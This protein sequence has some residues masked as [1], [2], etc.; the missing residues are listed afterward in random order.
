MLLAI[1]LGVS[2][3]KAVWRSTSGVEEDDFDL[4]SVEYDRVVGNAD[5]FV[6]EDP[7]TI[8]S[9]PANNS[10]GGLH[11]YYSEGKYWFPDPENPDGP[12]I[13]K[14]GETNP[15]NFMQHQEALVRFNQIGGA[16]ASAYLI[17]GEEKYAEH[18]VKHVKAWYIDEETKMNPHMNYSQA[19]KGISPGR[20][21]GV[22]DGLHMIEAARGIKVLS[23]SPSFPPEMEDEVIDWFRSYLD[24]MNTSDLGMDERKAPNNHAVN[25]AV[26]AATFA[27]LVGDMDTIRWVQNEFKTVYLPNMQREDGA[28][29]LELARTKPYQYSLFQLDAMS[30]VAQIASTEDCDLWAFEMDDGRGMKKAFDFMFPYVEDKDSWFMEPDVEYFDRSPQRHSA[31]LYA[32]FHLNRR[33]YIDKWVSIDADPEDIEMLKFVSMRY[34]MLFMEPSELKIPKN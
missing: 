25:W 28:F 17:T 18:F 30:G 12:Y 9:F 22:I 5:K 19:V 24:W 21:T 3:V 16:L 34:P 11:D 29:P 1:F 4:V 20:S 31:F 6:S 33:D 32:G 2:C 14:D 8:T 23:G 13:R 7:V 27:D 15:N 10:E 26:Q